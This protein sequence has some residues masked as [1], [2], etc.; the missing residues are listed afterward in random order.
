M[1]TLINIKKNNNLVV[2]DYYPEGNTEDVGH[3][4][5]NIDN[6]KVLDYRYCKLDTESYL[7]TYYNKT[8]SAI[9]EM[10]EDNVKDYPQ[11]YN[12]MWY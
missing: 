3:I 11:A 9:E 1:V 6:K 12:Y 8:I 2:V 10:I 5:Y 4:E 7:K